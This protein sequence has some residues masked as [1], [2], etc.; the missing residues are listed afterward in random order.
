MLCL[1]FIGPSLHFSF[2]SIQSKRYADII[3]PRGG[4]NY[5]AIDLLVQHIRTELE[6][7]GYDLSKPVESTVEGQKTHAKEDIPTTSNIIKPNP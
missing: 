5:V 2:Y 7:R 6:K 3:I 4:D 1:I